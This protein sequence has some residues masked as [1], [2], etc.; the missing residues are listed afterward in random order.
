MGKPISTYVVSTDNAGVGTTYDVT[1]GDACDYSS[2]A[3][4]AEEKADIACGWFQESIPKELLDP[5]LAFFSYEAWLILTGI[6]NR[7]NKRFWYFEHYHF[8]HCD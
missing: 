3:Q 5:K 4:T 8:V 6:A 2:T 1:W 7:Q